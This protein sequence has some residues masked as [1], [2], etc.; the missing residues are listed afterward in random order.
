[1]L[2]PR[3]EAERLG[4]GR[5]VYTSLF[6]AGDRGVWRRRCGQKGRVLGLG[7]CCSL[8]IKWACPTEQHERRSHER[9]NRGPVGHLPGPHGRSALQETITV[10]LQAALRQCHVERTPSE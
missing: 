5:K 6:P 1:M 10:T 8:P 3:T 7:L 2:L 4:Q 9:P